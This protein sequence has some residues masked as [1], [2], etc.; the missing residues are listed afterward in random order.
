MRR[1]GERTV[2]V[3]YHVAAR[4]DW[5]AALAAGSY[6]P[7]SLESAGFMLCA[8]AERYVDLANTLFAG[9]RDLVL[10]FVDTHHLHAE[11][12]DEEIDGVPALRL[13]APLPLDAAYE[14]ADFA[15]DA[16]GRFSAHHET[17]ALAVRDAETLDEVRARALQAMAAFDR[18][19][20][21]AGGWAVDIFL[22]TKTRP[23][24]D[25]EIAILTSDQAALYHYFSQ[26]DLR[27]AAPGAAFVAWDGQRLSAPYHQIWARQGRSRAE[28]PDEFS[29]DPTM[30]D[31]LIEDHVGELWQYRRHTQITRHIDEFGD[32]RGGIPFVR[33]EVA[34][35]FK[36]HAP[37]FK[38]QRDFERVVPALDAAARAWLSA[39][40]AMAHPSNTWCMI[41]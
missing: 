25:L 15:P 4:D 40:L 3:I 14:V 26:W 8:R 21:I 37:R 29:A 20:W 10:L 36:A 28:T 30:L 17:R 41:L 11:V 33:P 2:S 35:L 19:W 23:H 38:D 27:V 6:A 7:P 18:P 16:D 9:Q 39:A 24:A 1:G 31:V 34:L 13:D 12:R 32:V 5:Q 22:G